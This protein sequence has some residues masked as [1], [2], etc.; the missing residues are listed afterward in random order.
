M[1]IEVTSTYTR[2]SG[3][4]VTTVFN[5]AFKIFSATDLVVRDILDSTDTPTTK[6]N[7]TDYTVA[8]SA[9]GEGGTV[10]FATAPA[11]GHS[12]D[13]RS[14]LP[15]TQAEDIRNQGR[16]LPEIHEGVFDKLARL[17][18]DTRRLLGLAPRLPDSELP[19][20]DWDTMLSP[21]NRKGKYGFFFN[22]TT[23]L[24]EL[25]TSIGATALSQSII[26]QFLNPQSDNEVVR[27]VTPTNYWYP[28]GNVKRYG[29]VGDGSTND[30]AAI[31]RAI[32]AVS[33]QAAAINS[34]TTY[35]G[36]VVYFPKGKYLVSKNA[37]T[38]TTTALI[39]KGE[40]AQNFNDFKAPATAI[41]V[42]GTGSS[43]SDYVFKAN[44]TENARGFVGQDI[45]FQYKNSF[46]GDYFYWGAAGF[47]LERC[48]FSATTL[49]APYPRTCNSFLRMFLGHHYR[50]HSCSF[51]D[52]QWAI[53]IDNDLGAN[54]N[55]WSI[56]GCCF[57]DFTAGF[58]KNTGDG[59]QGMDIGGCNF[60][61]ITSAFPTDGVVLAGIGGSIHGCMFVGSNNTSC[62]VN[63]W[64]SLNGEWDVSGNV[65]NY[66]P[67]TPSAS[68]AAILVTGGNVNISA[69][70]IACSSGI[71][72]SGTASITGGG[73]NFQ[74]L[75]SDASDIAVR[76][77]QNAGSYVYI[78][79]D[80][81]SSGFVNSYSLG[82]SSA[83]TGEVHYNVDTDISTSGPI[84]SNGTGGHHL[85]PTN[86]KFDTSTTGTLTVKQ[87]GQIFAPSG[88]P[89]FTTPASTLAAGGLRYRFLKGSTGAFTINMGSGV[90]LFKG[91]ST[92]S[93]IANSTTEVGAWIEILYVSA[94]QAIVVA[95]T[96]TWT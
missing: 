28:V 6:T 85:V 44:T 73:N 29:A 16:F 7:V 13:I 55:D 53:I 54:T 14:V 1:T 19:T 64:L 50:L 67:G 49:T 78:G 33:D 72:A 62:P 77:S 3:N 12:I 36:G 32:D 30:T 11:S 20:I 39:L 18:Q 96:G 84:F 74:N 24:P 15:L 91:A 46:A 2:A 76:L 17:I 26:G 83:I 45:A 5:F 87:T 25:F 95:S 56:L 40:G 88:T 60:D 81:V 4:G 35:T 51:S 8:I 70:R 93:S 75:T 66:Q 82:G 23:G 37:F 9:T 86:N 90:T 59:V 48:S 65:F 80:A 57:Y 27:G 63:S 41:I 69:N 42:D 34:I 58:I 71:I 43:S 10:T 94:T 31:Q 61:P 92:G 38:I 89:T 52:A 21:A 47:T 22:L 68:K 79:P